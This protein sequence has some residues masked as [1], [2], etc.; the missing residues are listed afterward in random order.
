[1]TKIQP[2]KI[3]EH[4]LVYFN[5]L[6][7]TNHY[8]KCP[9]LGHLIYNLVSRLFGQFSELEVTFY[10]SCKFIKWYSYRTL[11]CCKEFLNLN[12]NELQWLWDSKILIFQCNFI[13]L[14]NFLF[15]VN[16]II[17]FDE[18]HVY[19]NLNNEKIQKLQT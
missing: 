6:Y 12:T 10:E 15:S 7:L 2:P 16:L 13:F 18:Y 9:E 8:N 3:I 17:E 11:N 1:M 4:K 14:E 5:L 19:S